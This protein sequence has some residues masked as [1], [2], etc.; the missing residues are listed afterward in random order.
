[1]MSRDEFGVILK[2]PE[3]TCTECIRY[4]C[5]IEIKRCCCDFARYGCFKFKKKNN[6][7]TYKIISERN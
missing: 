4:P 1:M 3:R 7:S 2:H 6:D 5:F